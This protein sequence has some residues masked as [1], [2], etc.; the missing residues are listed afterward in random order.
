VR[1]I[2]GDGRD[3]IAVDQL[4]KEPAVEGARAVAEAFRGR[5]RRPRRHRLDEDVT[6]GPPDRRRALEHLELSGELR[7]CHDVVGVEERD[8]GAARRR[9]PGVAGRRQAAVRLP[10]DANASGVAR[11]DRRRVVG[12]A[13]VHHDDVDGAERLG[14]RAV[15]RGV[16]E[17]RVVERGDDQAH[18]HRMTS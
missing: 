3:E 1:R 12:R 6:V 4:G 10:E 8:V 5:H 9:E 13:V 7:R 16:E 18:P 17:A 11:Q 14:Q 2:I 15:D